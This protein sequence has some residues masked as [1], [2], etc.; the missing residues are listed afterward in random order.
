MRYT[1]YNTQHTNHKIFNLAFSQGVIF[2]SF[3]IIFGA[4]SA[5]FAFAQTDIQ[6][7]IGEEDSLARSEELKGQLSEIQ[8]EINQYRGEINEKKRE[9]KTLGGEVAILKSRVRKIQLELEQTALAL[10]STELTIQANGVKIEELSGRI[11]REKQVIAELLRAMYREDLRDI[12]EIVMSSGDLSDFFEHQKFLESIQAS[13]YQALQN[14][15]AAKVNVEREQE[16]LEEE[17]EFQDRLKTLQEVQRGSLADRKA[18]KDYLL[19]LTRGQKAE[20]ERLVAQKERD[21]KQI[22]NQIF[23][24][25]GVGIALPLHKAYE[26][27]QAASNLTGTRPAFLL[28][29]LKQESSWGKNVGQCFLVDPNTGAGKG[30]NTGNIYPRTMKASRDVQPFLQI[31]QEL[32]RDP[33]NT[34]VSCPHA[35]YGYGGAMGPAQFIPSTWMGYKDRLTNLLGHT[36]DPWDITDAFTASAFKLAKGGAIAQTYEKEWEAAMRYYAGSRWNRPVYSFYGD[37][38]MELA[39]AIQVEITAM[40]G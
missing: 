6:D 7:E 12:V 25:E 37:S 17:R 2:I 32:G 20:F 39:A 4:V 13:V 35:S 26:I 29:V 14:V 3:I 8:A 18:E 40:G 27:A 21:V 31:T 9:E 22:R 38:V 24:L 36:P 15:K 33:Y 30:K 23:L 10:R 34:L 5:P 19:N 11:E 16:A 28:A 1:I